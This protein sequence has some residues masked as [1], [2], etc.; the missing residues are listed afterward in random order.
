M[1]SAGGMLFFEQ[2]S[3]SSPK[4]VSNERNLVS[5]EQSSTSIE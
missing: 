2:I 1:P 3:V 5:S 4:T